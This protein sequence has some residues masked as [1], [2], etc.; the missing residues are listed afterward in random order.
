MD[1]VL[2]ATEDLGRLMTNL[3]DSLY[4]KVILLFKL[5]PLLLALNLHEN[6]SYLF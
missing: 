3:V 5:N 2:Q 4:K 1:C 6:K